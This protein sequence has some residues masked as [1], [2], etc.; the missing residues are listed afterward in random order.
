M[1]LKKCPF[2]GMEVAEVWSDKMKAEDEGRQFFGTERFTV[3]CN[4]NKRGCG[5]TCGYHDSV[6][7]AIDKWNTRVVT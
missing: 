1:M 5:A 4:F 3:V 2:C 6:T 7:M